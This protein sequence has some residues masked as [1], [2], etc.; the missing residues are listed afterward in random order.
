MTFLIPALGNALSQDS[1]K[2]SLLPVSIVS[3]AAVALYI[4]KG[5]AIQQLANSVLGLET[6]E[7]KSTKTVASKK[8]ASKPTKQNQTSLFPTIVYDNLSSSS[9][10]PCATDTSVSYVP[11]QSANGLMWDLASLDDMP[12][13]FETNKMN[14]KKQLPMSDSPNS[15][16]SSSSSSSSSPIHQHVSGDFYDN[17]SLDSIVQQV[18]DVAADYETS[19]EECLTPPDLTPQ[20]YSSPESQSF[21]M[22]LNESIMMSMNTDNFLEDTHTGSM[23]GS[24]SLPM[25]ATVKDED[26]QDEL[27]SV[28][29]LLNFN[30][31]SLQEPFYMQPG[32]MD[33]GFMSPG[34]D[35]SG[36]DTTSF[37]DSETRK[38]HKSHS[39]SGS[40]QPQ[41]FRCPHCP[42]SF[43]IRGYLTR[44]MKKHATK[45]AY[46]CPFYC[47]EDKTP[48][49]PSGG[50]SRRDTYKTHLKA[51][52]F[53]YPAGTRSG[54]RG[55]VGGTC[56]GCGDKFESNEKWVEEHIHNRQCAGLFGL[57]V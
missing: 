23:F 45:K 24:M 16:S 57:D 38:P 41:P 9:V 6:K 40:Q 36:A 2:A 11:I 54:N 35:I 8:K 30:F 50:F 18:Q 56:C 53:L 44:H 5:P 7:T 52:H 46:S 19:Q 27:G 37:T 33:S 12:F 51:R 22:E 28:H 17:F 20:V 49:H 13:M 29:S 26:D 42:S 55:K 32:A 31:D 34:S 48:C 4:T 15:F 47:A 43:R 3:L 10:V 1:I 25:Q 21:T 14:P 39:S